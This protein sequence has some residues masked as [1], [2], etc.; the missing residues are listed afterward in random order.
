MSINDRGQYHAQAPR[1][2]AEVPMVSRPSKDQVTKLPIYLDVGHA[3]L[4]FLNGKWSDY[5]G[6]DVNVMEE[7]EALKFQLKQ[8]NAEN[9]AL[10]ARQDVLMD[11]AATA[12]LDLE[13]YDSFKD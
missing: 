11:M 5:G 3:K 8:A 10:K 12:Q 13:K 1:L 7:I 9:E 2:V 6:D 4:Q